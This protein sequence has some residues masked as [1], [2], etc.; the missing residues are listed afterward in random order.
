[1]PR[2]QS[3]DGEELGLPAHELQRVRLQLVMCDTSCL[4]LKRIRPA[5]NKKLDA[6]FFL[7]GK[8]PEADASSDAGIPF[9]DARSPMSEISV[10]RKVSEAFYFLSLL[11]G[12]MSF[13]NFRGSILPIA[14]NDT[15]VD[16]NNDATRLNITVI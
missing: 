1:L 2:V 16:I 14:Q 13:Q 15:A 10:D 8:W 4:L 12:G 3:R 7:S 9:K 6:D 5:R 11:W